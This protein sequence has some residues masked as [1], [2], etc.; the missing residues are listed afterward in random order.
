MGS[1]RFHISPQREGCRIDTGRYVAVAA[2]NTWTIYVESVFTTVPGCIS[3]S[4][5]GIVA[6]DGARSLSLSFA[7]CYVAV[8]FPP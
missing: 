3:K 8:S 1:R 6:D 4:I 2:L 5:N 7:K